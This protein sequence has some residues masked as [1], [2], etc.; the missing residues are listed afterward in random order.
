VLFEGHG[1]GLND[2]LVFFFMIEGELILI[3]VGPK[4]TKDFFV[5]LLSN[6]PS[7]ISVLHSD[8]EIRIVKAGHQLTFSSFEFSGAESPRGA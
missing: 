7:Y 8:E 5:A 4:S 1:C 2:L 3:G 6:T